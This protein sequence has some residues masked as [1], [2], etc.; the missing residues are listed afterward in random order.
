MTDSS[1]SHLNTLAALAI[2]PSGV[3]DELSEYVADVVKVIR[4]SGLHNETHSMFT[5]IEGDYDDVMAVV[6]KATMV[7]ADKG[8]R[9]GV[10]LKLDIRPGFEQQMDR[11][12]A[13]VDEILAK[14]A[15]SGS[16]D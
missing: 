11:K 1:Q 14:K 6:R 8:Y 4:E 15:K 7:L 16:E 12:P 9:T 10:T 5:E 13:L 3:G 2:A